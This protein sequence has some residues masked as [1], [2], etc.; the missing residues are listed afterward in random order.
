MTSLTIACSL[1]CDRTLRRKKG[2]APLVLKRAH[3]QVPE[4]A[5]EENWEVHEVKTIHAT[6]ES[7]VVRAKIHRSQGETLDA[8]IK[9]DPTGQREKGFLR[10]LETYLSVPELQGNVLPKL[11]G[12]FSAVINSN[13]VTCLVLE[14]CGDPMREGLEEVIHPFLSEILSFVSTL[15]RHGR[16]HGHIRQR[17]ILVDG[18]S[19]VLIDLELSEPHV[20]GVRIRT[21]PGYIAPTVEEYGCPELHSL[22][23]CMGVWKPSGLLFELASTEERTMMEQEAQVLWKQ[24][25]QERMETYGTDIHSQCKVR[26]DLCAPGYSNTLRAEEQSA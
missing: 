7:L 9:L 13:V 22:L 11:Y 15:H 4:G 26:L 3:A 17:H 8:V 23:C 18:E 10:E 19:P 24:L 12:C 2:A 21:I 14:Y 20:C 6:T 1:L 16:T 5:A 25:C